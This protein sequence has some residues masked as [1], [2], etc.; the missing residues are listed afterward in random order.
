MKNLKFG[1]IK[2]FN[3]NGSE[4]VAVVVRA[5]DKGVTLLNTD[6]LMR[7]FS[8]NDNIKYGATRLDPK[9]RGQLETIAEEK[10]KYDKMEEE[11]KKLAVAKDKQLEKVRSEISK[12]LAV[13]GKFGV[14]DTCRIFEERLKKVHPNLCKKLVDKYSW[15][16]HNTPVGVWLQMRRY[17]YFDKWVSL[18]RY[19]FLYKEY[20]GQ[21]MISN[22]TKQ[23]KDLCKKY[24]RDD[25]NFTMNP[26]K[27]KYQSEGQISAGDKDSLTYSH[28][29]S[30][31]LPHDC[32]TENYI[33]KL[34]ATIKY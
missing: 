14:K 4:F 8:L 29:I 25:A 1:D 34:V 18:S 16:A 33:D 19:D 12:V 15:E 22:E 10:R 11:Y 21:L 5:N 9:L 3:L 6:G 2:K 20:D 30:I 13:Q 26:L 31:L 27:G 23:Y 28:T 7:D 17:D 24:G 32:L